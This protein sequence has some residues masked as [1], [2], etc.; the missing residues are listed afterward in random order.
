MGHVTALHANRQIPAS[1][2]RGLA[3]TCS[4]L[5]PSA[6]WA[7]SHATLSPACHGPSHGSVFRL[8]SSALY[9]LVAPTLHS[10]VSSDVTSP[11]GGDTL[12]RTRFPGP[13]WFVFRHSLSPA[14]WDIIT[15]CAV[16]CVSLPV[17]R[18][19]S[20]H[21]N[22]SILAGGR[23]RGESGLPTR[24]TG[25]LLLE[26]GTCFS[27]TLG[28]S[29]DDFCKALPVPPPHSCWRGWRYFGNT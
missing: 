21:R 18:G 9:F 15:A 23:I 16:H 10:G 24:V 29:G 11:W 14:T 12:Q 6:H 19:A 22:M 27:W 3:D 13:A 20:L 7:L 5:R 8:E 2:S 17:Q 26:P 28:T 4:R 1:P 25:D